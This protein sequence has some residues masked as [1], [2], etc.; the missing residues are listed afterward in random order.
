MMHSILQSISRY[1]TLLTYSLST[2]QF[3][4]KKALLYPHTAQKL[5]LI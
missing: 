3:Q 4:V 1:G 5:M 2:F